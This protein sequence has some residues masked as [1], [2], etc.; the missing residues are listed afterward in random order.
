[1]P[2]M[3][4]RVRPWRGGEWTPRVTSNTIP[5]ARLDTTYYAP[6]IPR[7]PPRV[8]IQKQDGVFTRFIRALRIALRRR[9]QSWAPGARACRRRAKVV[10]LKIVSK[11][12]KSR[13][14]HFSTLDRA[15]LKVQNLR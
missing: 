4:L 3:G 9:R 10:A 1:M 6:L 14:R 12:R 8:R 5:Q 15:S 2:C 11:K 7:Q 13:R